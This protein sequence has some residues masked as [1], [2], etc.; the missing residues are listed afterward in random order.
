MSEDG[1][2]LSSLFRKEKILANTRDILGDQET[3]EGLVFDTLEEFEED[4]NIDI[5]SNIFAGTN[6]L[7][8]I[9]LPGIT[10]LN[11]YCLNNVWGLQTV[12]FDDIQYFSDHSVQNC[13]NLRS[14]ILK[15]DSIVKRESSSC[16]YQ[17]EQMYKSGSFIY[18][19]NELAELYM[20]YYNQFNCAPIQYYP[21]EEQELAGIYDVLF[22]SISDSWQKILTNQ[23]YKEDYKIG[24]T[25]FLAIGS[26]KG[27]LMEI[28]A[29]DSDD[30]SDG[31]GKSNITW[32]AKNVL[33]DDTSLSISADGFVYIYNQLKTKILPYMDETVRSNLVKVNKTYV[34]N[35][36]ATKTMAVEIWIPSVRELFGEIDD[37]ETSGVIYDKF[38]QNNKARVRYGVNQNH[39]DYILRTLSKTKG[40]PWNGC[41]VDVNGIYQTSHIAMG[42]KNIIFGFCTDIVNDIS[43]Q[44]K[45]D[46]LIYFISNG[47]YRE[48]YHIGDELPYTTTD[49]DTY[50]A[51][52][53]GIDKDIDEEGN[54]IPISFVT[55]E[56]WK[57]KYPMNS[58][59]TNADG[60][61]QTEMRNTTLPTI[62][63]K[64]PYYI[65]NHLAFAKKVSINRTTYAEQT[66]YDELWIPSMQEVGFTGSSY[67]TTGAV[68]DG[69]FKDNAARI[70]MVLGTTSGEY[71]WT[72]TARSS[73]AIFFYGVNSSGS[74]G[75]DR[76]GSSF[77]IALGFCVGKLTEK[78]LWRRLYFSISD[79]TYKEKY[80]IGD[81][82]PYTTT[83][84]DTYHAV[85]A[86]FDLD[87]DK[88]GNKLPVTF[89]TKELQKTNYQMNNT[90]TN[91]GGWKAS[92]LRK[93]LMGFKSKLPEYI[94]IHIGTAKKVSYDKTTSAEQTTYDELWIPS[95]QEVNFTGYET[96]GVVYDELF[97]NDTPSTRVK[98][99]NGSA[100]YYWTRTAHSGNTRSFRCVDSSGSVDYVI[101]NNPTGVARVALGFCLEGSIDLTIQQQWEKLLDSIIN[102]TYMDNYSV[103]DEL[104]FVTTDGNT[105]HAVIAG[106]NVDIDKEGN[107]LPVTFITKELSGDYYKMNLT[108]TNEGGWASTN[109]RNVI[110][111]QI[112][113]TLPSYIA[114]NILQ[115]KKISRN[116]NASPDIITYDEL[117]IPSL[118]EITND[119]I[120]DGYFYKD[121]FT[122][123][124]SRKKGKYMESSHQ[125]YWTRSASNSTS[126]PGGFHY[127]NN[128]G[129]G[130]T[131]NANNGEYIPICFCFG[132]S[133]S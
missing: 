37:S 126:V 1:I 94:K 14:I 55:K 109:L 8:Y 115:A 35:A 20:R 67:E 42:S 98:N 74:A 73:D 45:W 6:N 79:G 80:H 4:S 100:S 69:L 106:F 33:F 62:K 97:D 88:E 29:F 36:G 12:C 51:V 25:K 72:R 101:A 44:L 125:S 59:D 87:E 16:F 5:R 50:T 22:S 26:E 132:P 46:Q 82:L 7:K 116:S 118:K 120:N 43:E 75:G 34:D 32:I 39:V 90:S 92:N 81:E 41:L 18:A 117:W 103:G 15:G 112:K 52:I 23:N 40:R 96:T 133:K 56:L 123:D 111:P 60:W 83:D 3:L 105:Y 49:G 84:G 104:P 57:T 31:T 19:R 119:S 63:E 30:K 9:N 108:Q 27:C 11:G 28:V 76:A 77:A 78:Q 21:I 38:I 68:Y 61:A 127:I 124:E 129:Q 121:L 54:P 93:S 107:E 17:N 10:R 70:K 64:L 122:N 113:A 53:A 131:S 47:T 71:W 91:E 2:K 86:G 13:R 58:S 95:M 128:Q 85:I 24:D 48:K 89:I 130:C 110:L 66:T 102:D 114:N 65:V 99:F